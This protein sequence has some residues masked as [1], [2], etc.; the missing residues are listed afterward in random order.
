MQYLVGA[1]KCAKTP[2]EVNYQ[3]FAEMFELK[4]AKSGKGTWHALKKK[5][6]AASASE[7]M[8][9][10]TVYECVSVTDLLVLRRE[11]AGKESEEA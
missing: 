11:G 5:L 6:E 1:V 10:C 3:Q 7:G 9:S 2:L 8:V 4:D